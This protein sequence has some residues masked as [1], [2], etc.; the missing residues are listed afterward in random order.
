MKKITFLTGNAHKASEAAKILAPLGYEIEMFPA[1]LPEIQELSVEKI[2]T[3]K[4]KNARLF[5]NTDAVIIEDT[6]FFIDAYNDFPG[7]LGKYVFK[8]I[9][10]PGLLKLADDVDKRARFKT[11]IAYIPEFEDEPIYFKGEVTGRIV[12]P[13]AQPHAN[14]PFDAIFVPDGYEQTFLELGEATK[15]RISHRTKALNALAAYLKENEN[16]K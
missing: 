11:V 9:G 1:D 4:A 6:G 3:E 8:G 5:V 2:I 16:K 13:T 12:K 14:M 7:A 15:N 10:F